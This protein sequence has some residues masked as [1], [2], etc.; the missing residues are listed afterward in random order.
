V[1]EVAIA[2]A[3]GIL[4]VHAVRRSLGKKEKEPEEKPAPPS[5]QPAEAKQ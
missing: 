2:G 5:E 4:A 1:G 3:A